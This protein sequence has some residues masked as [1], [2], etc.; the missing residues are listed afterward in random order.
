MIHYKTAI[1]D[2][3]SISDS[4]KRLSAYNFCLVLLRTW[5]HFPLQLSSLHRA[6]RPRFQSYGMS[7][8]AQL[9]WMMAHQK[10]PMT[11]GENNFD[12]R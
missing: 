12:V 6:L 8:F 7:P 3:V 11:N 9:Q 4:E 2:H 5:K 1:W 10:Y